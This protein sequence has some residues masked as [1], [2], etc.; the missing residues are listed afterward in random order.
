MK[1]KTNKILIIIISIIFLN[2]L[3]IKIYH[4][5]KPTVVVNSNINEEDVINDLKELSKQDDKVLKII[6]DSDKYPKDLLDMLSRN[7]DLTNYVLSFNSSKG[8]IYS[9]NIGEVKRGEFPL[10]MQY[11]RRWGYG[12][13]GDNYIAIN[14]CG[15]TS[16]AIVVAG[17]TGRNDVTPY[18]VATYAYQN[19]YYK[20][21]TSWKFFTEGVKKYGIIGKEINLDK[22]KMIK[23][24]EKG[25][26]IIC[27]MGKGDFTTTGHIIV[28]TG[29]KDGKFIIN[30][31]NSK[32]RS[33][34]LWSYEQISN[35]MKNLWVFEKK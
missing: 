29:I 23:E 17:L 35:Q 26:P 12:I 18:K 25:H 28:I 19:G 8:K 20:D 5:L 3:Y 22:N 11:D 9:D 7:I 30:D 2:I 16:V 14:G 34:K 15:P 24:L 6:E 4:T 1:R 10:L 31:P 32:E 27:S 21:G 13:Y 33:N